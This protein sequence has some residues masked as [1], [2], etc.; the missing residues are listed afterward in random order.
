MLVLTSTCNFYCTI[1]RMLC[2][3]KNTT[4]R[5]NRH[6][7][8]HRHTRNA[9]GSSTQKRGSVRGRAA[10]LR[11]DNRRPEEAAGQSARSL[12]GVRADPSTK[13]DRLWCCVLF[14]SRMAPS[15]IAFMIFRL[16]SS[17]VLFSQRRGLIRPFSADHIHRHIA[18]G[19]KWRL[20]ALR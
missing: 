1:T 19:P 18:P 7:H 8:Q 20:R 14:F 11:E 9:W 5:S 13:T 15:R 6:Q 10:L 17:C 12:P 4:N 2:Y 3:S 16:D